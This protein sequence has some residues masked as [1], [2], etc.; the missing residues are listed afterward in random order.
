ML[1]TV[2]RLKE[3]RA[4]HASTAAMG[5]TKATKAAKMPSPWAAVSGDRDGVPLVWAAALENELV[6]AVAAPFDSLLAATAIRSALVARRSIGDYSEQ[7]VGRFD[8]SVV[9]A[10]NRP[11]APVARVRGYTGWMTAG[12]SGSPFSRR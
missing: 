6:F 1:R 11:S 4:L 5:A 3:D 12:G 2:L 8:S 7:E 10:M 9:A